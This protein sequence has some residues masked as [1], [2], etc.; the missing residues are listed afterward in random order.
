MSGAD[1]LSDNIDLHIAA[2]QSVA[3]I[4]SV[5]VFRQDPDAETDEAVEE[6]FRQ[7]LRSLN[8]A[9]SLIV[10]H[11]AGASLV[12]SLS[13]N[14]I[15]LLLL[16]PDLRDCQIRQLRQSLSPCMIICGTRDSLIASI[17]FDGMPV[18]IV[19]DGHDLRDSC[20]VIAECLQQMI[21][22]SLG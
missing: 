21:R 18:A 20:K 15:P 2:I 9:P 19:D 16:S 22:N 13:L 10:A 7:F 17:D 1:G 8:A 12:V 5:D 4:S 6:C 14:E 11:S 3:K